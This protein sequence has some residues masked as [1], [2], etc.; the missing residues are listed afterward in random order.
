MESD[1]AM[2]NI[3]C[4]VLEMFSVGEYSKPVVEHK[5]A[6]E[7]Y[8]QM[9]KKLEGNHNPRPSNII[10]GLNN[11]G[12]ILTIYRKLEEAEN[13]FLRILEEI[14][15]SLRPQDARAVSRALN[16]LALVKHEQGK[17]QEAEMH[18]RRVLD[19]QEQDLDNWDV[20]WIAFCNNLAITLCSQNKA[21]EARVLQE[22]VIEKAGDMYGRYGNL[23]PDISFFRKNLEWI[24]S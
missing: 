23:Y 3:G 18:L 4:A 10:H 1:L 2:L 19:G 11:L 16:N 5:V 22:R 6:E 20:D 21:R 8:I 24:Q 17:S 12:V 15:G 9:L 7:I 13:V 14:G